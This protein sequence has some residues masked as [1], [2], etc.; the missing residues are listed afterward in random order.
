MELAVGADVGVGKHR[1]MAVERHAGGPR[2]RGAHPEVIHAGAAVRDPGHVHARFIDVV[3]ALHAIEQAEQV[4]ELRRRPP[5]GS[6]PGARMEHDFTRD[7]NPIRER[8]RGVVAGYR[9]GPADAAMQRD[10]DGPL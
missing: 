3:V 4:V 8:T 9:R 1:W 2:R 10:A 7:W 5:F 6:G